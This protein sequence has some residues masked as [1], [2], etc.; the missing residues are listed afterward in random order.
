MDRDDIVDND[1][2][3]ELILD[4]AN[5]L[6]DDLTYTLT[7]HSI[8][9]ADAV[10]CC[11]ELASWWETLHEYGDVAARELLEYIRVS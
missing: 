5:H 1:R 2:L 9:P 6:Y 3:G 10:E 4:G 8:Y 7:R 11:T